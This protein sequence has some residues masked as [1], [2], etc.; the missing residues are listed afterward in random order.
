MSTN[1]QHLKWKTDNDLQTA[2]ISTK[3]G[4]LAFFSF[5]LVLN[6]IACLFRVLMINFSTFL[7]FYPFSRKKKIHEKENDFPTYPLYPVFGMLAETR[8]LLF[9]A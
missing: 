2:I 5:L 6:F 7:P 3:L 8:L 4:Q 1:P 9:Y